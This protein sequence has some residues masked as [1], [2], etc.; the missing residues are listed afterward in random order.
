MADNYYNPNRHRAKQL[1]IRLSDYEY[2]KF[3]KLRD[4]FLGHRYYNTGLIVELIDLG[5]RYC[6]LS[7]LSEDEFKKNPEGV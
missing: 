7:I 3:M 2:Y 4:N 5:I 1:N 6:R